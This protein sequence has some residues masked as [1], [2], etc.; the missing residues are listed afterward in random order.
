MPDTELLD[1]G[2]DNSLLLVDD[3]EPFLRRLARAMEK[4]GFEPTAVL[5]VAEGKD[6]R[7]DPAARLCR[8]RSAAGGR[9]RARRG[10]G[11]AREAARRQDRGAYGI[12]QHRDRSGGGED[13]GDGLHVQARGRQRRHQGAAW[14]RA[15]P[16]PNRPKTRCPPTA[17]AGNISSACSNCATAMSPKPPGGSTCTAAPCSASS[18]SAARVDPGHPTHY[19]RPRRLPPG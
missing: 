5:T 15:T 17:S 1:I 8:G 6:H 16:S 9:Q 13:R 3:D 11:A 18:P 7:R 14:P 10:R 2:P 12:W 19:Q 4:R